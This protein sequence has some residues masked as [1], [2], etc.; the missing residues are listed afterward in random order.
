MLAFL[1]KTLWKRRE[2]AALV[3]ASAALIAAAF[4]L[5]S[6]A[7][8]ATTVTA[9]RAL[10][11]YWRTTY[12]ILV[13]SPEYVT[14]IE[15]QYGLV[16]ANHLSGTPGGITMAQYELIR[17][18]PDVEVAAPIAMLGY[19]PR[20]TIRLSIRD[21]L[22]TGIYRVTASA[23][24]WDGYEFLEASLPGPYYALYY[25]QDIYSEFQTYVPSDE[26][27]RA[28]HEEY[29]RLDLRL[30]GAQDGWGFTISIPQ[31]DDRLLIAAIDPEQEAALMHLD[32]MLVGDN[33]VYLSDDF[34]RLYSNIDAIIIPVLLNLHDYVE[35][36]MTVRL[37]L[38][39]ELSEERDGPSLYE[40]L[41]AIEGPEA[42]QSLPSQVV[43]EDS[44]QLSRQRQVVGMIMN[45]VNGEFV[46]PTSYLR[47]YGG[48]LEVPAPVEYQVVEEPLASLPEDA[49]VLRASPLGLTAAQEGFASYV[50][51]T[52][53]EIEYLE[54][55]LWQQP[56]EVVF[57]E[58]APS[59]ELP[60]DIDVS[61]QGLFEIDPLLALGGAS[62]NQV[63][64]ETYLTPLV[65]L[66]YDAQGNPIEPPATLRPT[67]NSAGYLVAP[68]DILTTL[69]GARFL[70][71]ESCL[72]WVA[73]DEYPV[74][75][76]C[77]DVRE[78]FI[79]AIRVR[80]AGVDELTPESQAKIEA[81][82]EQIFEQTGLHVDIMVGSS[83]QPVLVNIPGY[84]DVPELGYVEELWVKKGVSTL[85][86]QGMNRADRLLFG[87]MLLVCGLF[88]FNANYVGMLGRV[89]EFGLMQALGWRKRTLFGTLLGEALLL[90]GLSGTLGA[91]VVYA[92]VLFFDLTVPVERIALLIP[93]GGAVFLVGGLLPAWRASRTAPTEA[94]QAGE[95]VSERR[96]PGGRS[97]LGYAASGM[98]RR[99][100]RTLATGLG[101]AVAAGLLV[102]LLLVLEGLGGSLY[103]T[104][105]GAWVRTQVQSYH[106]M[107]GGVALLA[108]ALGIAVVMLQNVA[109]RR[110]EIGLLVA[111]GWRRRDLL[112][113]FLMEGGMIGFFG[114]LLGTVVGALVFTLAY[115]FLRLTA[116]GWLHAL[117]VG[118][119]LPVVIT[120]LA[121]LY[122]AYQGARLLPLAAFRG[123]ER[124]ASAGR[125]NRAVAGLALIGALSVIL[126][127]G[128]FWAGGGRPEAE[129]QAAVIPTA[130]PTPTLGPAPSPQPT[131]TPVNPAELPS[132]QLA[133]QVD[134]DERVL[135]GQETI[136]YT[137]DT[138]VT[139]E[140][141]VLRLYPNWPL[142]G[143]DGSIRQDI[144]LTIQEARVDGAVVDVVLTASD[145]AAEIPLASPL[146]PG[147]QVTVEIDFRLQPGLS[148]SGQEDVWELWHFYPLLAAHDGDDWQTQV[149]DFCEF[150]IPL[151][152][153]VVDLEFSVAAPQDWVVA[154]NG[155]ELGSTPG[156]EGQQIHAY[157]AGPVRDM[158]VVMG[159]DLQ[160]ESQEVDGVQ[161]SLYAPSD[162]PQTDEV[163]AMAV[164]A[165]TLFNQKF[166]QYPYSSF[167][168]VAFSVP[169]NSG[170][171]FP[172]LVSL[173]YEQVDDDLGKL[174]A[175][176]IARQ[177]W[178][179][180]VDSDRY[181]EPWLQDAFAEYS[182][183]IYVQEALGQEVADTYLGR[184][185]TDISMRQLVGD[186]L[187][188]ASSVWAFEDDME[189]RQ[190]IICK[191]AL[192]L[193]TLREEIGDQAFFAGWQDYY[194]QH[195]YGVADGEAFLEAMQ[196]AAGLN[197]RPIF[198][199]WGAIA[200]ENE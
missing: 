57:R 2:R 97:L 61:L 85:I 115:P 82:A 90:G 54:T 169:F 179:A 53:D 188:L 33:S 4:A 99:P 76:I 47:G 26:Q 94:I 104:L 105:L 43:W 65:T 187:P 8:L 17:D 142:R 23:A 167:D 46:D 67:L 40:Q 153:Q 10:S 28:F 200:P 72:E 86:S 177:W 55:F 15:K 89:P 75:R 140:E 49:L 189:A 152:N 36:T 95:T 84:E 63:P 31:F 186:D 21:L 119:L 24:V 173:Y 68:P 199:T 111:L 131:P 30:G 160:V 37:E 144:L 122:P 70:L 123:E 141:I 128:L 136:R 88:L 44:I 162:A 83:P 176:L 60:R 80:V 197:L 130:V 193:D 166:G 91:L 42:Y 171:A 41:S 175:G 107:M 77:S 161:V 7:S 158:V 27:R 170:L 22:P 3:I 163:L 62:P 192:F 135:I 34:P 198:E 185:Q 58:L 32:Q 191:G 126:A 156:P 159:P 190:F 6:S 9:D 125:L 154:A 14:E 45:Y 35:Q 59:G 134:E 120:L 100:A 29:L 109:G 181:E 150:S 98:L 18:L 50:P 118:V 114:G 106:L 148:V 52:E 195:V 117:A 93:L 165:F 146:N 182:A 149:C 157:Q 139:L 127:V 129:P 184:C 183:Y 16:E 151:S 64:L 56:P 38:V 13:R 172:R 132:V 164:K 133:L 96:T 137:N 102:F 168:I 20:D 112:R 19:I 194:A 124:L 12:D 87:V 5:F 180:V 155:L 110:R 178:G 174:L 69:D 196:Q 25:H 121:T 78:D 48:M 74:R 147:E 81:V 79:S 101:L 113:V 92:I 138:G 39:M 116:I 145:T 51:I 11:D 73:I 1:V 66:K 103:G 108:S 143:I 71:E